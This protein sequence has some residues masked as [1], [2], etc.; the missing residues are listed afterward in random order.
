MEGQQKFSEGVQNFLL[1]LFYCAVKI[2]SLEGVQKFFLGGQQI[3]VFDFFGGHTNFFWR[4]S[5]KFF[6][7][8]GSF[9]KKKMLFKKIFLEG[10]NMCFVFFGRGD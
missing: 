10:L 7:G 9:K 3:L 8:W 6:F 4:G 1:L 2:F 5:E